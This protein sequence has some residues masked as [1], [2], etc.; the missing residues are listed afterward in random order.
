MIHKDLIKIMAMALSLG[1]CMTIKPK[2]ASSHF[3][4]CNQLCKGNKGIG[5]IS[6]V[7]NLNY[8]GNL[9][10]LSEEC[11]CNNNRMFIISETIQ[12]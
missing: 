2:V 1:G 8:A 11:G 4:A 9:T 3:W 6:S 12:D 10:V 5:S 7:M